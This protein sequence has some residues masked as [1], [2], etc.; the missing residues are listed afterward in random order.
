MFEERNWKIRD[1][2]T[3][4]QE[5]RRCQAHAELPPDISLTA[6]FLGDFSV[7]VLFRA[8]CTVKIWPQRM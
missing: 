6:V 3:V 5:C 7:L 4:G 2:S 1:H 8:P